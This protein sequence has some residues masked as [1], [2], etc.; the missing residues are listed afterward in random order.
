MRI[1]KISC[2]LL[3]AGLLSVGAAGTLAAKPLPDPLIDDPYL[4]DPVLPSMKLDVAFDP[5]LKPLWLTYL[6][7]PE[8]GDRQHAA[9]AFAKAAGMGMTGFEEVTPVMIELLESDDQAQV[10]LAAADALMHMGASEAADLLLRRAATDGPRMM[11]IADAAL[12]AWRHPPASEYWVARLTQPGVSRSLRLA[13]VEALRQMP[14]PSAT[15]PLLAMVN[16]RRLEVVLRLPAAR[17]LAVTA[18]TEL[19]SSA[20]SLYTAA[21]AS[22]ADRL[23]AATILSQHRSAEARALYQQM[24]ADPASVVVAIAVR[25]L[26]DND[27]ALVTELAAGLASHSDVN[28]RHLAVES[29]GFQASPLAVDALGAML[30]DPV[31]ALRGRARDMLVELH[32]QSSLR[33]QIRQVAQA[34][35]VP[36]NSWRSIEQAA[37]LIG[38]IDHKDLAS[39]VAHALQHARHEVRMAAIA[40]LR[41]LQVEQTLPEALSYGEWIMANRRTPVLPR[42]L[43]SA[44]TAQLAQVFGVMKY[45]SASSWLQRMV[46][47][48]SEALE[49]R[50]AAIWALG[51]VHS[52]QGEARVGNALL[53]RLNDVETENPEDEGVRAHAAVA[54]GRMKMQRASSALRMWSNPQAA[55]LNVAYGSQWALAHM[56]GEPDPPMLPNR[57]HSPSEWFAEFA[58]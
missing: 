24:A 33:D 6:K 48:D 37:L 31:P 23:V 54:L 20:R 35:L 51:H 14:T 46:P 45:A 22:L 18:T 16:D 2:C 26:L 12:L 50:Y 15:Q 29:Y 53:A 32:Q 4:T 38:R 41:W 43:A 3:V 49:T 34:S 13:A 44:E 55:S 10:R 1:D 56:A 36:D 30:D 27:P 25:G 9:E 47:K 28:L 40:A 8:A 5:R 58:N 52:D 57:T 39:S 11:Q 42:D 17:S 19:E 7:R 21:D